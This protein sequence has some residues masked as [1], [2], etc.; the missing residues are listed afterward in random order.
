[1]AAGGVFA[2]AIL[3]FAG[4]RLGLPLAQAQTAT[5]TEPVISVVS[6]APAD[7]SAVVT[8]TTDEMA[9][10]QVAYG[11]SLPYTATSTLDSS[12]VMSHSEL[13]SGLSPGTTYHYEVISNDGTSTTMSADGTFMTTNAASTTGSTTEPVISSVSVVPTDTSA[14][15]TWTTDQ[16]ANSQIAYGT[17]L[18]YTATS[19]LDS[20]QVTNHSEML[21]GL[22]PGTTYHYEVI[23][24][25]GTNTNMSMDGTFMTT[26][27]GG[28]STGSTTS[29]EIVTLQGQVAQLQSEVSLLQSQVAAL[30]GGSGSGVGGTGGAAMIDQNGQSFAVNSVLDFGGH[31]FNHEEN[32]TVTLN[33]QTV[34]TAHADGGGNFST[35]NLTAPAT[36]GTYTYVFTGANGDS[37]SA[38]ITVH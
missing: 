38:T 36:P 20:N 19:T 21:S 13:L 6:V 31:N 18:P 22:T 7:T 37:A 1:V 14:T 24:N 8:W 15:V 12:M 26:N 28:G 10:S 33:G 16:A 3:V 35:G 29:D 34:E 32:V 2:L 9:N 5:T 11:T 30:M 23:S 17:S 4:A 25:N 27:T